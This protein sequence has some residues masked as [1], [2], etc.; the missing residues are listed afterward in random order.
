MAIPS[1]P[2]YLPRLAHDAC[3]VAL[4]ADVRRRSSH[5]L[6]E[7]GPHALARLGAGAGPVAVS[8]GAGVL[9]DIP[10]KL[11]GSQVGFPL[12][13]RRARAAGMFFGP[14]GAARTLAAHAGLTGS[15]SATVLLEQRANAVRRS[16]NVTPLATASA[17][18]SPVDAFETR[19]SLAASA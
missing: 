18:T 7:R 6:V 19:D 2:L 8:D 4:L 15:R 5:E 9:T 16:L 1:A 10:W 13:G 11:I 3:G 12:R 17:A 14:P